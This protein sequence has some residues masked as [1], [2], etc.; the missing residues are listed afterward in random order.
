MIL[1]LQ[2]FVEEKKKTDLFLKLG[3]KNYCHYVNLWNQLHCQWRLGGNSNRR[4]MNMAQICFYYIQCDILLTSP[5]YLYSFPIDA[6]RP[7]I[8]F[9][10]MTADQVVVVV[11]VLLC[12]HLRSRR[13][14]ERQSEPMTVSPCVWNGRTMLFA[15]W[16]S[17]GFKSLDCHSMLH[18][19]N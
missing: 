2:C 16:R 11:V 12:S 9:W 1:P 6:W 8:Y 17:Q 18:D 19:G 4:P 14:M 15:W 7:C 3:F 10:P 13:L 5:E